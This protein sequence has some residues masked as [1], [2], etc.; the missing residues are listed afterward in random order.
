MKDVF[1]D[2]LN[3]NEIIRSFYHNSYIQNKKTLDCTMIF[4]FIERFFQIKYVKTFLMNGKSFVGVWT[5]LQGQNGKK[6]MANE[7]EPT[8]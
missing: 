7:L 6:K 1:K 2:S 4:I 3:E 8:E 5:F